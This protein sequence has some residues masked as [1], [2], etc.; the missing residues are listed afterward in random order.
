MCNFNEYIEYSS[1]LVLTSN[2][3]SICLQESPELLY[4]LKCDNKEIR[5]ISFHMLNQNRYN[6][7]AFHIN[8]SKCHDEDYIYKFSNYF[9]ELYKSCPEFEKSNKNRLKRRRF[10]RFVNDYPE[11]KNKY[12]IEYSDLLD[13]SDKNRGNFIHFHQMYSRLNKDE[14]NSIK[15]IYLECYFKT[16]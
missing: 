8:Y 4:G 14:I 1:Q 2:I 11:V 13:K 5:E 16:V 7:E 15:K 6:I 12:Q 9:V 3:D 10:I